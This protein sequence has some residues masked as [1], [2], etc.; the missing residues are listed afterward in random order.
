MVGLF[1]LGI[2]FQCV[3]TNYCEGNGHYLQR[4]V[5]LE[6]RKPA[7]ILSRHLGQWGLE[8]AVGGNRSS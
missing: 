2:C 8:R 3:E 5:S 4:V 1:P 7:D 6:L